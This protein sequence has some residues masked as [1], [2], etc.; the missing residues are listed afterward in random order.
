MKRVFCKLFHRRYW[1][2]YAF[3]DVAG[4]GNGRICQKCGEVFN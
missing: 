2:W 1:Y 3:S 4:G